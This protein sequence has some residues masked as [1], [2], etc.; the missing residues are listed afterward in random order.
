MLAPMAGLGTV[1]LAVAVCEAGGL[2][3]IGCAAMEPQV[4]A[5]A[6]HE[7]RALTNQIDQLGFQSPDRYLLGTRTL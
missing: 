3:S 4:V 5:K 1:E 6:I 2:G 7:L